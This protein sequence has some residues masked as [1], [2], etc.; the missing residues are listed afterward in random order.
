MHKERNN[1]GRHDP[2]VPLSQAVDKLRAL[3]GY[4]QAVREEERTRIAREIHDE[5]GQAMTALKMSL[6]WVRD[7]LARARHEPWVPPLLAR[8]ECMCV[9]MDTTVQ[10]VRR[11]ATELRP[12]VLDHLGLAAA[13]Q[14]QGEDFQHQT[15]IR[16][17]VATRVGELDL[18]RD[19]STAAFRILQEALTNVARHAGASQVRIS[20]F[21][22]VGSLVLEV[23]DN[24]RGIT[25]KETTHVSSLGILGMRE[26]A[27]LA[28]GELQVARPGKR[29]TRVTLRIPCP[30]KK[31]PAAP[32]LPLSSPSAPGGV[33]RV[34][35]STASGQRRGYAHDP[36]SDR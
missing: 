24:G 23:V 36:H 26:R 13:I 14:W 19:Q 20:L 15:G 30:P 22:Q 12:G 4:L 1:H 16:C 25:S 21:Q 33:G 11:I 6:A 9:L 5:L 34:R 29:G 18:E 10:Q 8:A 2:P 3:A 27:A 32:P 7:R 31:E 28:G 35:G 17:L